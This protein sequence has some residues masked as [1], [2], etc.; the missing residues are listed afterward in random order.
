MGVFGLWLVGNNRWFG[1]AN[2]NLND[3]TVS[4]IDVSSTITQNKTTMI[5]N[6][7][8]VA[9]RNI[10]KRKLYALINAFGLCIGIAFCL[11][12]YLFIQDEKSFDQ[13]QVN[14]NDIYLVN[15]KRFEFM[16]FKNGE[17]DPFAETVNQNAKLGEVMLDEL[18][19]VQHMS[20]YIAQINGSLRYQEKVFTEQF[21]AVDSGFFNMFSFKQ[22]RGNPATLFKNKSDIVITPKVAEK[23]FGAENPIGKTVSINLNGEGAYTVVGVFEA[24]PANSSL[25]ALTYLFL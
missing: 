21:T 5:G 19:E 4:I 12:I 7:Y 24:P 17:K 6:Y 25:T 14:K 3:V 2:A 8:K 13:F 1:A 9:W 20:R 11:F 10:A 22:L 15:N 16:A 18:A 23:Y